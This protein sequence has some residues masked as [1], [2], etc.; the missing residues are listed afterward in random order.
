VKKQMTSVEM[1]SP[2]SK[3]AT[4]EWAPEG[5][6]GGADIVDEDPTVMVNFWPCLQW[7]PTVQK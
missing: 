2:S 1:M 6:G 7:S 5:G 4:V 3:E